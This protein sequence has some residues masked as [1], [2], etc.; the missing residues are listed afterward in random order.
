M[1]SFGPVTR[2]SF[3]VLAAAICAFGEAGAAPADEPRTVLRLSIASDS[4]YAL[5]GKPVA[6]DGLLAAF[7]ADSAG[8]VFDLEITA[9][10]RTPYNA[11]GLAITRA[12]EAG[13]AGVK[14]RQQ[15]TGPAASAPGR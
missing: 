10:T 3:A 9:S 1:R 11:I 4:T 14:L 5:D 6:R 12:N 15:E 2:R 8:R 13:V 7:K